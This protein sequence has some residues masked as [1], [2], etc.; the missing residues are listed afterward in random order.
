MAA[1]LL[2]PI[3]KLASL[4][5]FSASFTAVPHNRHEAPPLGRP[6]PSSP[7]R[8]PGPDP[9]AAAAPPPNSDPSRAASGAVIEGRPG[10]GARRYGAADPVT[11]TRGVTP[12]VR[13]DGGPL[14]HK[15]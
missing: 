3:T 12:Q 7:A 14:R 8:S 4:S 10:L 1:W 15:D 9:T 13:R 5:P 6:P 11:T 2:A